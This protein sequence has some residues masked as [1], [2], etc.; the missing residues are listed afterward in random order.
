VW[1]G[2]CERHEE[3]V[4]P[5]AVAGPC[6]SEAR[7][8]QLPRACFSFDHPYAQAALESMG[9]LSD[10]NSLFLPWRVDM[11]IEACSA[12][13]ALALP[14]RSEKPDVRGLI[15]FYADD[16]NYFSRLGTAPFS[17]FCH[18]AEIIWQQSTFM[19]LLAQEAQTDSLTGLM[20]RRKMTHLLQK[21]IERA[22]EQ[23][24]PLSVMLVRIEGF[25]N[26]NERYGWSAADNLLTAFAR[27]ITL[28]TR[29]KDRVARWTGVEFLYLMPRTDLRHA[30]FFAQSL[31]AFFQTHPLTIDDVHI[32][33]RLQIGVAPYESAQGGLDALVQKARHQGQALTS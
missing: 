4:A 25:E 22:D 6:M 14:L 31:K 2:F 7:D 17:A 18:V 11:E 29:A 3:M 20:N 9:A 16:V 30:Q 10:L 8:W 32:D 28:Q 13:C 24:E 23:N 15:V 19:H 33:L 27:E 21:A 5:H 26:I 1:I 12:N